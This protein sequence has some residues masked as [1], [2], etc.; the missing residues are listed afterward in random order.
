MTRTPFLLLLA[1]SLLAVP[2]LATGT[3][4][5]SGPNLYISAEHP[6]LG[7]YFAG[8]MVVEVSIRD[9]DVNGVASPSREPG[10]SINGNP[11]K[12][13][14]ASNG[15]WYA[16]FANTDRALAA[17]A[18]VGSAG[19]GLDFGVFCN[20]DTDASVLGVSFSGADGVALPRSGGLEGFADGGTGLPECA[21]SLEPSELL[22]N[23][24]RRPPPINQNLGV[25]AGQTGL[26]PDAWP[27]VQLFSFSN[28]VRIEYLQAGGPELVD[29]RYDQSPDISVSSDREY[30]P[31]N[32]EVFLTISDPQLN[33]DPTDWDTWTFVSDPSPMVFYR[34]F[35]RNG[36]DAAN[37]GPGMADIYPSLRQLGFD[38]NGF[39]TMDAGSALEIK[40]NGIQP[41]SRASDGE[42]SYDGAVSFVEQERSS[43]IFANH[44]RK[45]VSNLGIPGDAPRNRAA[46]IQ[47]NGD[48]IGIITGSPISPDVPDPRLVVT[49]DSASP[50][51]R[52]VVVLVDPGQILNLDSP[53][54]LDVSKAGHA[55]PSMVTGSPLTL[56]DA[57]DV[58]AHGRG[59]TLDGGAAVRSSVPDPHAAR[60]HLDAKSY[61]KTWG[62]L[63]MDL[64]FSAADLRRLL[65][66]DSAAG[67]SGTSWLNLDLR[68]LQREAGIRPADTSISLRFGDLSSDPVTLVSRGDLG[69]AQQTMLLDSKTIQSLAE[70]NGKAF[71]V[72]DFGA[73]GSRIGS[74]TPEMPMVMDFVSFGM[75]EERYASNAVY[76][77]ELEVDG[78]GTYTGTV[79][80]SLGDLLQ[81]SS[82]SVMD[83]VVLTGSDVRLI[84]PERLIDDGSLAIHYVTH[85]GEILTSKIK[86]AT[87]SGQVTFESA[88]KLGSPAAIRLVDPDLNLSGSTREIYTVVDDPSSPAVDAVGSEDYAMLEVMLKGIRY[89]RCTIDGAEYGGLASTGFSLVETGTDTGVFE[90]N[91]KIPKRICDRTGT[92]LISVS[93]GSLEVLYHDSHTSL[94]TSAV[95][96]LMRADQPLSPPGPPVLSEDRVYLSEIGSRHAITLSGGIDNHQKGLQASVHITAPNGRVENFASS[97]DANGGYTAEITVHSNSLPGAYEIRLL[98]AGRD[99]GTV[100]LYV[101]SD[102]IPDWLRDAARMWSIGTI[103]DDKF[104]DGIRYM[105]DMEIVADG[106]SGGIQ[107][108]PQWL[109]RSAGWWSE[110]LV[111]DD[112]FTASV[113]YL[114]ERGV[115]RAR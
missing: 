88:L 32:A 42:S 107:H 70:Q 106:G 63:S 82:D 96:E 36:A 92:N 10:V 54:D 5:A 46:T 44:D 102:H 111:T 78:P 41:S 65:I 60:L 98:H 21:G 23:V 66:D 115:I 29:L 6:V 20:G 43:F 53:S 64:G 113:E 75:S 48:R 79:E 27:V 15:F 17:D 114:L 87:H 22:N 110:G 34:A 83:R 80:Y 8:S 16:Y 91:F 13:T 61:G 73:S 81:A 103:S 56:K 24:V 69:S 108:I 84:L 90:G 99:V 112:Q 93:G 26:D 74:Q 33:Q 109:A 12:M 1:V 67:Q 89:Q 72:L 97:L 76:R 7:N 30:Y 50:G 31:Q 25:A 86:V 58:R 51:T 9:T 49:Q 3:Y 39:L 2:H 68:A 101:I 14:Q 38:D 47:Y 4:G 19:Q 57:G 62:A 105:I 45:N 77:M 59:G 94:G 85:D 35:D 104:L 95:S 100:M 11:L 52:T 37:G 28:N 40:P 71:A 18:T 55:I